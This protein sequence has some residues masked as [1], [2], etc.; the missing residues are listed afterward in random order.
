S[1]NGTKFDGSYPYASLTRDGITLYGMTYRGGAS[2]MGTMFKIDT[3]GLGFTLLHSFNGTATDGSY[4]YGSLTWDG[5]VLYGMTYQGGASGVGTII[6][7]KTDG[8]SFTLLHSFNGTAFD[9]S[10]P[11][12]SLNQD[13]AALYGMT[14]NGGASGMGTIFKIDT[15]GLGFTLLHSFVGGATDGSYPYGTLMQNG[16]TLYGLTNNGGVSSLGTTFRINTDGTSFTLLHSF[17]STATDCTNPRGHVIQDGTTLYG[18]ASNGGNY[19]MGAIYKINTDG[20]GFAFMHEFAGGA[21]DGSYPYGSLIQDGA[22][23]YGMTYQG[24]A[25]NQ[26]IIFSINTDGSSFTML[27]SFNGTKFDGSYPYASLTRDGITLYGMTYRGG[28][29]DIGTLFKI[30]TNGSSFTLLHS[31]N[32]TAFDGSYPYG[33]LVQD[34][35]ALYGMTYQG[36]VSGLGTIFS[37]TKAS[38]SFTLLHSFNGTAFDG[39]YPY[40][41]LTR[42]GAVL[43]GMTYRG[44]ASD[45]GT[46]IKINTDGSGF[47]LLR[48][49]ASGGGN[50]PYGSLVQDGIIMYGMTYQGGASGMGTAFRFNKDTTAFT[51]LHDFQGYPNDASYPYMGDISLI[52]NPAL[53][54]SGN[55]IYH[56]NFIANTQQAQDDTIPPPSNSWDNGLPD[57]GNYWSDYAGVDGNSD[58]IGN[59]TY[60]IPGGAGAVDNYPWMLQDGWVMPYTIFKSVAWDNV[61]Q[62]FWICGD[63]S[64]DAQSSFYYVPVSAPSTM[65]PISTPAISF[66]ALAVDELG[67]LLV[68]GNNL[69]YIYYFETSTDNG[70]EIAENGTGDMWGWNITGITFNPYDNR[71]YFV[72]NVKNTDTGVAFFTESLPLNATGK[73]CFIDNSDFMNFPGI[74]GLRSISWNPVRNYSLAV[75]DG[76]YRLNPYTGTDQKLSWSTIEG[77]EAGKSYYDISWDFNGSNEAGIVGANGLFGNYWRYYHTNLTLIDGYTDTVMGT[78]YRTCAMKPP[79]SPKWLF[80]PYNS[81]G[82]RVNILEK[83]EGGTVSFNSDFPHAFTVSVWKQSDILQT[84][85]LNTQVDADSTYTFFIEGNY[86][87]GGVDHWNDLIINITAWFDENHIGDAS[88]PEPN[89][90]TK[91]NRTRQFNITYE[92]G[93]PPT[94]IYPNATAGIQEF[95]IPSFWSDPTPYGSDG[96]THRVLINV[97]FGKQTWAADG[98]GFFQGAATDGETWNKVKALNDPGSW[99]MQVYMYDRFASA[100]FNLTYEEF[101]IKEFA[102]ISSSGNPTGSA[103]PGT[104]AYHLS[105]PSNI[106]YSSNTPYF[107]NIS[108][109]DLHQNGDPLNPKFIPATSLQVQNMH[110]LAVG[111][112]NISSQTQFLGA[113]LT[114]CVWGLSGSPGTPIAAP[115]NGTESAGPM[116]SD[117][118]AAIVSQSFEF[119]VIEWW[120]DVPAGISQGVYIGTITL[121]ITDTI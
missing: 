98:A 34:G 12:G 27:H 47:A 3:S 92:P 100:T 5:T 19:S 16:L 48:S 18:M 49:F 4:P 1:F 115:N 121:T 108:I 110:S 39:S 89:W 29:S 63:Y 73:K 65:V 33:S 23:L 70:Y 76:V 52:L 59:T 68:G 53:T 101:G 17:L 88:N 38:S 97:T 99:D 21:T 84:P 60:A 69:Q 105:N 15:S 8:S 45:L 51:V 30:N 57:G 85:Q 103:P 78:K 44:G 120:I 11:Y 25:S 114:L 9:G 40:G 80:I 91:E 41:S 28:A 67:N 95:A 58:G 109:P 116:Y 117:Y 77:P 83:D 61:H 22:A 111:S 10:Y 74:G 14:L 6:S 35:A 112:S 13:G 75:G 96:Y 87:V 55:L 107:V 50:Y 62:R 26:G 94:L 37:F 31:F 106:R 119:T 42:D 46:I 72:G 86:T 20:T 79:S 113:N 71:F 54:S 32:G 81:G 93:G 102:S 118:S 7:I 82:W 90:N 43:Y 36:G 64:A 104:V 2:N 24:G 66:S 56:N